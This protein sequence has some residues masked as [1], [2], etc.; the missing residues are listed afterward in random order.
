M[1][2]ED[3][4]NA[5]SQSFQTKRSDVVLVYEDGINTTGT[6]YPSSDIDGQGGLLFSDSNELFLGSE[7]AEQLSWICADQHMDNG[8]VGEYL[9]DVPLCSSEL[10]AIKSDPINWSPYFGT[11]VSYC[12][13]KPQTELYQVDFSLPIAILVI[14][15]NAFKAI[16]MAV[17]VFTSREQP[18]ITTGDA[19]A[20]FPRDHDSTTSNI[21]MASRDDFAKGRRRCQF[22]L[23]HP[24]PRQWT[25][26]RSRWFRAASKSRWLLVVGLYSESILNASVDAN[27]FSRY[28][29]ALITVAFLL[30]YGVFSVIPNPGFGFFWKLGLGAVSTETMIYWPIPNKG[31]SGIVDNTLVANAPQVILSFF[32]FTYNGLFTCM[33]LSREWNDYT[34]E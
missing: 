29:A 21:C 27:W 11:P 9:Y 7:E 4:I 20:S 28:L 33:L 6:E 34:R 25:A 23:H 32:Y 30:G 12:F 22:L 2:N 10:P 15:L 8:F 26:G 3:C 1:E 18:L 24:T 17:A 5:Y 14:L 31:V 19:I 13:S 16:V